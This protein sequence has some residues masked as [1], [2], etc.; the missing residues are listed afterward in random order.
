MALPIEMAGIEVLPDRA[1]RARGEGHR[2]ENRLLGVEA[3]RRDRRGLREVRELANSK[4]SKQGRPPEHRP[5]ETCS[6]KTI[7]SLLPGI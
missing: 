4:A 3:L 5:V 7:I 6:G 1:G 2:P